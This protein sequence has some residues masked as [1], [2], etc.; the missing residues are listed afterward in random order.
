MKIC[1]RKYIL[2]IM[3]AFAYLGSS[4]QVTV[5]NPGNATPALAATYTTLANAIT[6]LNAVTTFSGI[7]T[8]AVNPSNPQ[9]APA[10]G[11]VISFTAATTATK[12]VVIKGN[13]NVVVASNALTAGSLT[14][15]IF[16]IV[17]CDFVTIE[18]FLI[19]ENP[20]NTTT[21]LATNNMTE[22][23]IAILRVSIVA[24][25][26]NNI[27][28]NNNIQLNRTYAN[29]FG[30]YCNSNHLAGA[31]TVASNPTTAAGANSGNSFLSNTISN[32]NCGIAIIGGTTASIM[33]I[34][35]VIGASSLTGNTISNW[36]GLS[37]TAAFAG[38]PSFGC[39]AVLNVNQKTDRVSFNTI[40]SAA[41]SG[42]SLSVWGILKTYNTEPTGTFS[43][44]ITGNVIT[45]TS[46]FSSGILEGIRSEGISALATST[47]NINSNRFQGMSV[48][49]ISSTEI[50][51]IYNQSNCGTLNMN[52]NIFRSTSSATGSFTAINNLGTVQTALSINSNQIGDASG[53]AISFTS[54]PAAGTTVYGIRS[55]APGSNASLN[56]NS[57]NFQGFL[58]TVNGA[59]NYTFIDYN[60]AP[61]TATTANINNNTFTNISLNTGGTVVFINRQGIMAAN[62][63][64]TENVTGN[65]IVTAFSSG[66]QT[67]KFY[68]AQAASG[69]GNTMNHTGNN[70]SNVS[71]PT[72][73]ELTGW[74]NREGTL[75][76][77]PAKTISNN[78]FSNWNVQ[79]LTLV[80]IQCDKGGDG[81]VVSANTISQLTKTGS[82]N[83]TAILLGNGNS[84]ASQSCT[85]NT[86]SNITIQ[87]GIVAGIDADVFAVS[88]YVISSNI[89]SGLGN[90]I[91][92]STTRGIVVRTAA[93]MNISKN[94]IY[95][96]GGNGK[97]IGIDIPSTG[98]GSYTISNNYIGSFLPD[99]AA[100]DNSTRG[101]NIESTVSG[102]SF[103][104]CYNTVYLDATS[105][106]FGYGSSAIFLTDLGNAL[107]TLRNNIFVN[108]SAAGSGAFTV[109]HRRNN[110][111]YAN[112]AAAS[113]NNIFYAGTPSASNL[114]FYDGTQSDQFFVDYQTRMGPARDA[115]SYTGLPPFLSTSGLSANF[116]HIDPA[117]ASLV[118]SRAV[119]IAGF[120]DDYDADIRQG[121]AGYTGTGTGP[122]IGADELEGTYHETDAP[123]ISYTA[124]PLN[125][126]VAT[127][128]VIT[129]VTITD[130]TGIP[131]TGSLVPRIYFRKNTGSW[132]SV[133]GVN[134]AGTSTNSTWSFTINE[135][136]MG[137]V[138]L[139]DVVSYYIVAQDNMPVPNVGASPSTGFKALSVNNIIAAPSSL[140]TYTTT[141]SLGGVYTVGASGN[142]ATITAAVNAYN[143]SC[144]LTGPVI[145]ELIDNAY[146][147]EFYPIIILNHPDA[148]AT[149]TLTIRPSLTATPS[150]G[151]SVAASFFSGPAIFQL[152]GAKHVIIDG[153]RGGVGSTR[154]MVIFH[155]NFSLQSPVVLFHQGA[156][157][158]ELKYC[159]IKSCTSNFPEVN[160][161]DATNITINNNLV[162]D[163]ADMGIPQKPRTGVYGS[164]TATFI[165]SNNVVTDNH[166]S[167]QL[168]SGVELANQCDE[169]TISGNRIFQ[170]T[171]RLVSPNTYGILIQSGAGYLISNNVIG[172]SDALGTGLTS[173]IGNSVNLAGFPGSYSVSGTATAVRYKAISGTFTVGGS[174][175]VIS[176]NTIGG[177][178]LYTSSGAATQDGVLCGISVTGGPA[179]ISNNIIGSTTGTNSIYAA[180]TTS[181]GAIVGIYTNSSGTVAI[182]NN[183]IAGINA[184]GT[185]NTKAG[186][187]IAINAEGT[188]DYSIT[189]NTIGNALSANLRTGLT[190]TGASLSSVGSLTATT[191]TTAAMKGIICTSTGN[192]ISIT[193]NTLK[194]WATSASVVDVKGI[195]SAGFLTGV[196]PSADISN[197]SLGTA[198]IGWGS[199]AVTNTSTVSGIKL[200]ARNQTVSKIKYNDFRG[201]GFANSA[202]ASVECIS[203][204]DTTA[205]NNITNITGN[206]FSS[207]SV[208][209]YS[210]SLI[211]ASE[212]MGNNAIR[213]IDS[214]KVISSL[215]FTGSSFKM[216]G[217]YSANAAGLRSTIS[218]NE[219]S[220]A[221]IVSTDELTSNASIIFDAGF[222]KERRVE[223]NKIS[224]ITQTGSYCQAIGVDYSSGVLADTAF[225]SNNQVSDIAVNG[226]GNY[227]ILNS[228]GNSNKPVLISNNRIKNLSM[229]R[230]TVTTDAFVIG[231]G[232]TALFS[233]KGV[234]IKAN[235]ISTLSSSMDSSV[236]S[237]VFIYNVYSPGGF[238][239]HTINGNKIYDL[240]VSKPGARVSGIY[241]YLSEPLF[242]FGGRRVSVYNNMVGDLRAPSSGNAAKPAIAGILI[243]NNTIKDS[244]DIYHNTVDI[245]ATGSHISFSTA[246]VFT[247]TLAKVNCFGN[248][249]NNISTPGTAGKT[250]AYWRRGTSLT[251]FS[252]DYNSYYAGTPAA[253]RLIYFDGTNSDQTL[254]AYKTRVGA[255]REIAS[256][257][258]VPVYMS[259]I[260][261]DADFLHL[262][263]AANCGLL[264][265]AV[266]DAGIT[267]LNADFDQDSRPSWFFVFTKADIGADETS[268]LNTWTGAA[269]TSW[270]NPLNWSRGT[271][272]NSTTVIIPAAP[273]NQPVIAAAQTVKVRDITI[274]TGASLTNLGTLKIAG[275]ITSPAGGINNTNAGVVVG[276]IE[277]NGLCGKAQTLPGNVFSG[278]NVNNLNIETEVTIPATAGQGINLSGTLNFSASLDTL[279]TNGNLTIKSNATSTGSIGIILAGNFVKGDVTVERFINTGTTGG[280][281]GKSWQFLSTPTTG[282]TVKQAWQ[283]NGTAP[284]GFGTI[285]TGTGTGFDITT[286]LP[287]MKFYNDVTNNWTA[288]TNTNNSLVNPLG[289][290]IFVRGDRSVTTAAA[291]ATP[292]VLRSKGVIF[293]DANQPPIVMLQA[294]KFQAVGNPY[295]SRIEFSK[296]RTQSSVGMLDVF[297]VWD[298]TLAGSF[299][300]GGYQT[301]TGIAGYV[302]TVGSPPSGNA[303]SGLYPAGVAAPFIESGQAFFV[304][305]RPSPGGFV[306]FTEL[307]KS[308]GNRMVTRPA[309]TTDLPANRAFISALLFTAQGQLSDGNIVAF[310]DGL[311]NEVNENDADKLMNPGEN[312]GILRAE[313]LFAVE[314]RD[315]IQPTDT[316]FYNL[317]N[318]RKQ[319][320]RFCF[321][322]KDIPAGT[323]PLLVDSYRQT[324]TAISLYDSSFVDFDITDDPASAASG[325]FYLIF[326]QLAV[327][328]VKD[329]YITAMRNTDQTITVTWKVVDE[330]EM[331]NYTVERSSNGRDFVTVGNIIPRDNNGGTPSYVF[332]D[333]TATAAGFY[334]RIKGTG[335]NGFLLY[336]KTVYVDALDKE[337]MYTVYPNPVTGKIMHI[338]FGNN[339]GGEYNI[340]LINEAGQTVCKK[341]VVVNAGGGNLS[342]D[343]D[344]TLAAGVYQL[345][346]VQAERILNTQPVFIQ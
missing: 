310:E 145:F 57:N 180:T 139:G 192:S 227:G 201:I 68:Q 209:A 338:R 264:G 11:Y 79:A 299:G 184:S 152:K 95:E 89:I 45:L 53:N 140:N 343:I 2:L 4:S 96:L 112:Y 346:V 21:A 93:A 115:L 166:F 233:Q 206:T 298:P 319:G 204:T 36:G 213:T 275:S 162:T 78:T 339:T 186:S 291:A 317:Q 281:H 10:G 90:T 106:Q 318:L 270:S 13:N 120:T 283:E 43:S 284:A 143:T 207:L 25:A 246:A 247:D 128:K 63:G 173:L 30:I 294:D 290:M 295:A 116:L 40:T 160:I 24:G 113:N 29:S 61:T 256:V 72:A 253:N 328:P 330:T 220:N 331:D 175:S 19:R 205:T 296:V 101:I 179:S 164:G 64:A 174:T 226:F 193:G 285:I 242:P 208:T 129:G 47:I 183:T 55:Q 102:T 327:V 39:F 199:S 87:D 203:F 265:K 257:T 218:Y 219:I 271:V 137:G 74:D 322:L 272:P 223:F 12:T 85:G 6:A 62:A 260:G 287:S 241:S 168:I 314:A 211:N 66:A 288:V 7:V 326:R 138:V 324:T 195:E 157:Y 280:A 44:N 127:T 28:Q 325:R 31:P 88:S 122:D 215:S 333:R 123:V 119:N 99:N 165:S 178:A 161:V 344:K 136:L 304:R 32:V 86:I 292:T 245:R 144:S 258:E 14:D 26:Q 156:E 103:N 151:V 34:N 134:T 194:G 118:E 261:I 214:N 33:D 187:I 149:K 146:N 133:A 59:R 268:N 104:V 42:S 243:E 70:F 110:T 259:T 135:A 323:T 107:V 308:T 249:F 77:G 212:K 303:A 252:G 190:M 52:S 289:Y 232:S 48:N 267:E 250:V 255:T 329:I 83:A 217:S 114:V 305:C 98:S 342:I 266:N 171:A 181:G 130:I 274:N 60:H 216:I 46:S 153:R 82:G 142:F 302:P 279:T 148:S 50:T 185:S 297:Y 306:M 231:V 92:G 158:N 277:M 154:A 8:I 239:K 121:N 313:K 224:N 27:I 176:G 309:G 37:R 334:Y 75:A 332:A 248:L 91:F 170:T 321:S 41:L 81:T 109:A 262:N 320:Y 97:T 286:A 345:R 225:I 126:C 341:T 111:S 94:K 307:N 202:L 301:I 316:I 240:S 198:A 235:D 105:V 263:P 80:A 234:I 236:V 3:L 336:S 56:I 221:T 276:S 269:N 131:L 189:N 73:N 172:F 230:A 141:A 315:A 22:W 1:V 84:G 69:Q 20:S 124:L 312:F 191:G 311:S 23:G 293:Q 222:S 150:F 117:I 35:N 15:G 229:T 228:L 16:K 67:V 58:Q 49:A 210:L 197:N 300:Y 54:A 132:F 278:N 17:G 167:N 65:S 237:G 337:M 9:A 18:D 71:L 5:T 108:I 100:L 51:G 340:Q 282:Q 155:A 177:I 182:Q 147:A 38:V 159:I 238:H 169:W 196:N 125:F 163:A 335:K 251:N 76:S 273:V 254:A 244:I 188:A 200:V